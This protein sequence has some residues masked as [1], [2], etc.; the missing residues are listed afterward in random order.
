MV[1]LSVTSRE[2]MPFSSM[3]RAKGA[4]IVGNLFDF[5]TDP[6]GL[7]MRSADTLGGHVQFRIGPQGFVLVTDPTSAHKILV[8]N[9]RAY[10]KQTR[11]YERLRLLLGNG[12]LT[13]E[14]A[15]WLRQRRIAQPAFHR[16]RIAGFADTMVSMTND[17]LEKWD[18]TARE[19]RVVDVAAEMMTLT[20]RIVG[21][22]LLSTDVGELANEVGPALTVALERTDALITEMVPFADKWPTAENR[23]YWRARD[24]LNGIVTSI[25]AERRAGEEKPDLLSMLMAA[26]DEETGEQMTDAQ[27]RDEIMTMFLAGHE[28]TANLLAWTFFLL[29]GHDDVTRRLV[30]EVRAAA[31]D[32]DLGMR[33]LAKTPYLAAVVDESLRLYPPAWMVA[34]NSTE[35]AELGGYFVPKGT[36]HLVNIYGLHRLTSVWRDA[37]KFL[38]ERFLDDGKKRV[39]PG[40]YIPFIEG[41]RMCI[42]KSFALMEAQL[43]LGNIVKR[44]VVE[45]T[46]KERIGLHPAIT[47]RPKGGI[48]ARL[49]AR[50]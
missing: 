13:S 8:E 29:D 2:P 47:L 33:D 11:G 32:R 6:I 24:T 39:P 28:T 41:P 25:I 50:V 40:A 37:D 34:R 9:A 49:T 21:K 46:T 43:L 18:E 4:P 26:K 27:L 48:P 3:P 17:M 20:L 1:A 30:D 35:D 19:G 36:Y 12:L 23:A 44:F 10:D 45:R 42:G 38:P 22:T 7:F 5:R 14:G 15:F 16:D 31:P